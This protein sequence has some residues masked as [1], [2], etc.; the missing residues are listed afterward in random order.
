M[1]RTV[2]CAALFVGVLAFSASEV[3]AAMEEAQV[4]ELDEA[5]KWVYVPDTVSPGEPP[6]RAS[7]AGFGAQT[8][9]KGVE[10]GNQGAVREARARGVAR[11]TGPASWRACVS[12]MGLVGG[13]SG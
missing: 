5:A 12:A 11:R 1:R 3:S 2:L 13:S 4:G 7:H 8:P 10:F 6:H 9:C